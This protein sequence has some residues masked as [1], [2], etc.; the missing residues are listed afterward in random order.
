MRLITHF[1]TLVARN[2]GSGAPLPP[3]SSRI[4]CAG[5]RTE[6]FVLAVPSQ[7]ILH[8]NGINQP[9]AVSP[10]N[11]NRAEHTLFILG[12]EDVCIAVG[13]QNPGCAVSLSLKQGEGG[14]ERPFDLGF[15]AKFSNYGAVRRDAQQLVLAVGHFSH[16][17]F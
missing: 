9:A 15:A 7:W 5:K 1:Q 14:G 11:A 6:Y 2:D 16:R 13:L 4:R 8:R 10:T 3:M 12:V 17:V